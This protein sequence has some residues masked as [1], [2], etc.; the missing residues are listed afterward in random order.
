LLQCNAANGAYVHDR[1]SGRRQEIA[2]FRSGVLNRHCEDDL[3]SL[4]FAVALTTPVAVVC[5][6]NL[7]ANVDPAVFERICASLRAG[8]TAVVADLSGAELRAALAG[9]I[10]LLKVSIDE[11]VDNGWAQGDAD[12]DVIDGIEKL[13]KAGAGDVVVSRAERGALGVID[14]TW[15]EVE[16]P[17]LT[18]VDNR[19]AGDSLTAALAHGRRHAMDP[20]SMLR[21]GAAAAALNVTRRG[22]ASGHPD[23]IEQLQQL[24]QVRVVDV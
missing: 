16:S 24:V 7:D 6:S 5:G 10:D 19:G 15:M 1:R 14:G 12:D 21:L 4:L 2:A 13:R 17:S 22:L 11:L 8:G 20:Q 3:V 9:G 18:V 23:A